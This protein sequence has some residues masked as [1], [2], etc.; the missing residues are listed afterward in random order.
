MSVEQ[1]PAEQLLADLAGMVERGELPGAIVRIEK[2]GETLADVRVGYQDTAAETPLAENSIFRL[3]SMSKPITSVAIMMLAEQGL[4]N[5]DDPAERFLPGFSDLRVYESGGADDMVTVLA[6]RPIT[7]ADLLS[8]SSGITYHFAGVTPVHQYYR[9]HGV[10]R[11]TPVGRMPQ[12]GPAARTLDELVARIGKAPLLRQPGEGFDYSYSTTMLGAI[13]ERAIGQRLDRALQTLIFDPLEMADTRFFVEDADLSRLVTN[14]AALPS[15]LMP[16]E[17]AEGSEYRNRNR[18]LDGGGALA[19]TAQDY[20]NFCRML[21]DGGVFKG[22]RLLGEDSLR[23]MMTP[24]VRAEMP[25][26]SISF[27]YGF[28]LGDAASEASGLQ[29]AGTASWGGSA[30]TYFF[31]DPAARATA[32]LMTHMLVMPPLE[33]STNLRKLVNRTATALIRR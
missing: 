14:Y 6:K 7:I 30:S 32:L 33:T 16:I 8:H 26:L 9:Q 29:P 19:G 22:R 28:A 23:A 15:G 24:R 31:V 5:L 10:M 18:L 3:Y 17:T 20:L 11:D 4:L 12:D 25:P 27:G 1:K 13:V 2:N 21:T